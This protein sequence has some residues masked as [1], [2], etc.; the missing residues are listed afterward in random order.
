MA[1]PRTNKFKFKN[2]LEEFIHPGDN[3]LVVHTNIW[4]TAPRATRYLGFTDINELKRV[5][6]TARA[7]HMARVIKVFNAK[8]S[9]GQAPAEVYNIWRQ[10]PSDDDFRNAYRIDESTM[11]GYVNTGTFK[12]P[13]NVDEKDKLKLI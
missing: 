8:S 11:M 5:I 9:S 1:P 13:E 3:E 10:Y 6:Q 4:D 7:I 2:D 12:R